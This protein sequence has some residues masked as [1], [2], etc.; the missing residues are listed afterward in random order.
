MEKF[1]TLI[2]RKDL[3]VLD[4]FIEIM[5]EFEPKLSFQKTDYANDFYL[6]VIEFESNELHNKFINRLAGNG[7]ASGF[8]SF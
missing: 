8:V 5:N 6:L 2:K 3:A 1:T 7:I 4:K